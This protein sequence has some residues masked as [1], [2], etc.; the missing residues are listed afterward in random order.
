MFKRLTLAVCAAA[1]FAVAPAH[2]ALTETQ[3][4]DLKRITDGWNAIKTVQGGF[5]Q[6]DSKGGQATGVF[7]IRKPGRFRFDYQP[8][9]DLSVIADGYTV[10]VED[11]KLETQDRYP[12][13]ETPLSLMVDENISLQRKDLQILN[14]SRREDAIVVHLKSLKEDAQGELLIAFKQT[15]LSLLYWV[16]RDADGSQVTVRVGNVEQGV[17]IAASKFFIEQTGEEE[18]DGR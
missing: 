12:L 7:F 6:V 3:Q 15:D 16:V 13:V 1:A 14:V 4:A 9:E 5:T 8:P 17:D 18:D 2:A 11:R 10:A